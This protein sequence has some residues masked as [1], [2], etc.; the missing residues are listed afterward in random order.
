MAVAM[1]AGKQGCQVAAVEFLR[2]RWRRD[3]SARR[4]NVHLHWRKRGRG[5]I[6]LIVAEG[7]AHRLS[8]SRVRDGGRISPDSVR[9]RVNVPE[10]GSRD[11]A[12]PG[13]GGLLRR[14]SRL[15]ATRFLSVHRLCQ[16]IIIDSFD[17]S[18]TF[19]RSLALNSQGDHRFGVASTLRACAM[20][21]KSPSTASA[22]P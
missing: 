12:V 4:G 5:Q 13:A 6:K 10:A 8:I 16:V 9:V 22:H 20:L 14:T 18:L 11:F 15:G 19:S 17:A 2:Y 1:L 21:R 3:I 7:F